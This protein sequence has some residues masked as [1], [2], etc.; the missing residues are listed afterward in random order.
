[1]KEL[2]GCFILISY[3]KHLLSTMLLGSPHPKHRAPIH[4][5]LLFL[6]L[7]W[8][9]SLSLCSSECCAWCR[10]GCYSYAPTHQC[11]MWLLRPPL[12]LPWLLL[13]FAFDLL[14]SFTHAPHFLL[15]FPFLSCIFP[16]G[17]VEAQPPRIPCATPCQRDTKTQWL[18]PNDCSMYLCISDLGWVCIFWCSSKHWIVQLQL[19]GFRWKMDRCHPAAQ[20]SW[21]WGRQLCKSTVSLNQTL[22]EGRDI[23]VYWTTEEKSLSAICSIKNFIGRYFYNAIS[24]AISMLLED[25]HSG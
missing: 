17:A 4:H 8:P 23:E 18:E 25:Q 3:K 7:C 13:D 22:Q 9:C 5:H 6:L 10:T 1:M 24:F 11:S 12:T 19:P 16:G 14:V 21:C 15:L 2:R 20:P